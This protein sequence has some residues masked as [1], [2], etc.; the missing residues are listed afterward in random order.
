MMS[1]DVTLFLCAIGM[2]AGILTALLFYLLKS[3]YERR[4][5]EK[6][7]GLKA[8]YHLITEGIKGR[9]ATM[10][11]EELKKASVMME[12]AQLE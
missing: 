12:K 10:S 1:L 11:Q 5:R 4:L 8:A 7:E 2:L 6:D 3:S 9:I